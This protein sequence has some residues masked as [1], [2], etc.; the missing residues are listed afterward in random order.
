MTDLLKRFKSANTVT[1]SLLIVIYIGVA[2]LLYSGNLSNQLKNQVISITAYIIMAVSLNLVVGFLGELSL[3]H[4]AFVSVGLFTGCLFSAATCNSLALTVRL[5]IAM[6]IGGLA[7]AAAGF[8]VGLPALR[9]NGDYLAI[10]T[11]AAGEIVKNVINNL[12]IKS[13]D[14][15]GSIGLY[16]KKV[17]DGETIYNLRENAGT[18]LPYAVVLLFITVIAIVNL[19]KSRH[20]RAIMAIRDNRIA[21]E[22]TGLN[23]TYYKLLVFVVAAFFAGASGVLFGHSVGQ[24]SPSSYDYN[25]SIEIL[26]IVVLGGMGNIT[27]SIIAAIVLRIL[28]TLLYGFDDY[29]MIIYSILLIVI[30]IFSSSPAIVSFRERLNI[31]GKCI[32]LREKLFG[33]KSKK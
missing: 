30:M 18:L 31:N 33:N 14:F 6:L 11:L 1:Y 15:D 10:V 16:T 23:I 26:V 12:K 21:A 13:L 5:P 24:I 25:T 32:A 22:S 28:P 29:R 19:R 20:G 2:A 4:A 8:I 7:A 3:G 27:G 9:L 17:I